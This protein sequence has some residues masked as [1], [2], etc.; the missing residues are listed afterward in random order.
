MSF[1]SGISDDAV[2]FKYLSPKVGFLC[3]RHNNQAV[4]VISTAPLV[5]LT[6][7]NVCPSRAQ[8]PKVS[9]DNKN[10]KVDVVCL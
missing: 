4:P 3:P 6:G 2:L 1:I 8:E 10:S 7:E 5:I 9:G